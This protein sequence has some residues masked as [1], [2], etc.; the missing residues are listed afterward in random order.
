MV[1]S[2]IAPVLL[3]ALGSLGLGQTTLPASQPATAPADL[4]PLIASLSS[5]DFKVREDAQARLIAAGAAATQPVR[6]LASKS[7]DPEFASA[8]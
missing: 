5:S 6:E 8:P 3:L 7:P 1:C 4:A 2:R